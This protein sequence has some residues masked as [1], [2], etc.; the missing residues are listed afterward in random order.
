MD[1]LKFKKVK[2]FLLPNEVE[3]LTNYSERLHRNYLALPNIN[4]NDVGSVDD[5]FGLYKNHLFESLLL[6]KLPLME[7]ETNLKLF[8]TYSYWRMYTWGSFLKKHKDRPSCEISVTVHISG[9]SNNF[10]IFIDGEEIHTEPGDG[11]IY[12]G[13]EVPHWR[14]TLRED[15]QCQVFLH[16]VNQN[17]PYKDYKYDL[18]Q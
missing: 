13:I 5:D 1:N 7:K 15:F 10:P 6:Q 3:L 14:G 8:P 2:N 11:V 12:K 17:G 9:K 18:K 4:L 16:Y